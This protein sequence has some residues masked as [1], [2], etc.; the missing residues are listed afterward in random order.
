MK[1]AG[2]LKIL[3]K[4]PILL[5]SHEDL[6]RIK[7]IVSL[8]PQEAQWFHRVERTV[9]GNYIYYTIYE[10]YIPEQTCSAAEVDTSPEMMVNFYKSLK[11]EHRQETNDIMSNMTCWC[12]SHH[13]M[14]VN[15]SGQDNKQFREQIKLAT[16]R[17][18]S[19][20]Q[21]MIIFNKKNQYFCRI[22]DPEMELMFQN[23]EMETMS[24]DF[25]Y[26]VKETKEKFKKK[27]IFRPAPKG[28]PG[29]GKMIDWGSGWPDRQWA[30]GFHEGTT[31]SSDGDKKNS[32]R[33]K[34]LEERT[35][36][37]V[38][39]FCSAQEAAVKITE[40]AVN[41]PEE[42]EELV[43]RINSK[44]NPHD[45]VTKL[46]EYIE[47]R[48][49]SSQIIV[50]EMLL[51]DN[52]DEIRTLETC[53][54]PDDYNEAEDAKVQLYMYFLEGVIGIHSIQN[55]LATA[56][57]LSDGSDISPESAEH[58]IDYWLEIYDSSLEIS[59][60]PT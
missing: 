20:P 53:T 24:Y 6:C 40:L 11:K 22:W 50:L 13:S 17:E 23:P 37:G 49:T 44:H 52:E 47:T 36:Q 58:I 14:G 48:L 29:N 30:L 33:S 31:P 28:L 21:I 1:P 57:L 51:D 46:L 59:R 15:P 10:M 5:I 56:T 16:Q 45:E 54:P 39:S 8:A 25:D 43:S 55:A 7:H 38:S 4:N 26:L 18:L 27:Q 32:Q 12:H 35:L 60:S 41:L 19:T 34:V 9:E 3:N 2:T 42:I